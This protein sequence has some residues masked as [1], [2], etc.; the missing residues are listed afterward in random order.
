M[1][2]YVY[3]YAAVNLSLYDLDHEGVEAG[4]REGVFQSGHL[5]H[6]AAQGPDITLVVVGL[7]G[8]QLWTHV[9]GSSHHG[10]GQ[11]T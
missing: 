1:Y 4:G 6:A 8:E 9:V 3:R 11:I 10:A 5:I 7:V 2:M